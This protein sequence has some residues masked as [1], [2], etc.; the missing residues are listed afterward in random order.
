MSRPP[1]P[2]LSPAPSLPHRQGSSSHR[3]PSAPLTCQVHSRHLWALPLLPLC[4]EHPSCRFSHGQLLSPQLDFSP[5]ITLSAR[6]P[7]S[8]TSRSPAPPHPRLY[9]IM[10]FHFL[11][12]SSH[13]EEW[14]CSLVYYL[15]PCPVH[16]LSLAHKSTQYIFLNF[17]FGNNYR[18][19]K[20]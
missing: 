19:R 11:Q 9:H 15:S 20:L 18:L 13:C 14:S 10:P 1:A 5:K 7:D 2:S 12:S 17:L 3:L 4:P 8:T 16:T 6:H